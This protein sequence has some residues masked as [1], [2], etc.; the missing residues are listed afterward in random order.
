MGLLKGLFGKI[1]LVAAIALWIYF[2]GVMWHDV[3]LD[4][5]LP[6]IGRQTRG[7]VFAGQ[8]RGRKYWFVVANKKYEGV[9]PSGSKI[10][11]PIDIIYDPSNPARNRPLSR[12]TSD[13]LTA[14]FWT[15]IPIVL[16]LLKLRRMSRR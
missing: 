1:T 8:G 11:D 16:L 15:G 12:L 6:G 4:R 7:E 13:L 14:V 2:C 5:T 10:L 9:A 3:Y